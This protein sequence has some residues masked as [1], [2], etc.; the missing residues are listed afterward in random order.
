MARQKY[1]SLATLL[2]LT[3]ALGCQGT[4]GASEDTPGGGSKPGTRPGTNPGTDP[5]MTGGGDT[6]AGNRGGGGTGAGG[7][8]GGGVTPTPSDPTAAGPMPL[9]RL[10]HLEY[11][12][13]L[14]DLLGDTANRADAFPADKD[15]DFV[16]F[17][18]AGVV[19]SQDADSL[20]DAAEATAT[21]L[22]A[23][24]TTL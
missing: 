7:T 15:T 6:G 19:S 16:F 20:K 24:I 10:T 1:L 23:K 13:T 5:G 21:A 8:S 3:A 11:N 14:R 4:I 2:L 22:A 9:R 12:N 18:R 17:R